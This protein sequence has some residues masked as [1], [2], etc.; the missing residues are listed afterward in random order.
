MH[1]MAVLLL[2]IIEI[3]PRLDMIFGEDLLTGRLYGFFTK[4]SA[5]V[6]IMPENRRLYSIQP[7][8]Y[9]KVAQS[10]QFQK[11]KIIIP[12][13]S[14]R[15]DPRRNEELYPL[16]STFMKISSYSYSSK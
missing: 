14:T 1:L 7:K 4:E 13:C 6:M 10:K 2:Y 16:E 5:Y 8:Y 3:H 12:S 15:V 11:Q 9:N